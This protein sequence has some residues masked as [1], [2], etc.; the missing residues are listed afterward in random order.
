MLRALVKKILR[1]VF[2]VVGF[3]RDFIPIVYGPLRGKRM[4]KG[5]GLINLAML[6]GKYE[7]SFVNAFLKESKSSEVIYDIGSNVGYFSLLAAL[8]TKSRIYS[9]EPIPEIAKQFRTLMELN[10]LSED[11]KLTEVAFSNEIGKIKMVTPG[12]HEQGLM[13]SALRGQKVDIDNS[14]LV[15]MTTLDHL[16]FEEKF[17]PP[18][19]IKIDVEGAEAMV[20]DGG[21][22]T[23]TRYKPKL[24]I[25]VHGLAPA[26]KCWSIF[27]R[28]RAEVHRIHKNRE[29]RIKDRS[30]WI[31]IF[32]DFRW[33]V[34]HIKVVLATQ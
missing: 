2:K 19:L 18:D 23:L 12:T 13:V 27:E 6:F 5:H 24:L 21:E 4:L 9:F 10:D 11:V 28:H 30:Q 1:S 32:S 8:N 22:R 31:A 16:V 25:E 3:G 26:E 15:N 29:V 34:V 7:P 17:P 33:K 20:L 14:I